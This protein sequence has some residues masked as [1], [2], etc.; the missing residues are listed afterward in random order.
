MH[1][2]FQNVINT[3]AEVKN[4]ISPYIQGL[5]LHDG[6]KN[7]AAMARKMNVSE[8]RLRKQL[9]NSEVKIKSIQSNLKSIANETK[10]IKGLTVFAVDGTSLVKAF[11]EK[12]QNLSIDYDGVIRRPARCLSLMVGALI[13]DGNV[14]PVDCRFW[15]NATKKI[16]VNKSKT[17]KNKKKKKLN[18]NYKTKIMLAIELIHA[19]KDLIKFNYLAMDGA[20]ASEKMIKFIESQ[21]LQYS[22]RIP[23]SRRVI[24]DGNELALRDQPL[25]KLVRNERCKSAKGS[26]KGYTCTFTAHKRKKKSGTWETFFI[27]SNMELSAHGHV[28]AYSRRWPIDKSF[29]SMKQYLGLKDCQMLSGLKQTLHVFNVFLAYSMATIE[30][31]ANAKNSVE[32]IFKIC[33]N[34]KST[35]NHSKNTDS[36]VI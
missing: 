28:I 24:I 1:V 14:I 6:R 21:K 25:L 20:F 19:W 31:I 7:C 2:L 23:R 27:I 5:L 8:K 18:K 15:K 30:K 9:D 22:M 17:K 34:S 3:F 26:Y 36:A 32:E 29:R 11:A 10:F 35:K 13:S 16:G 33:R 4:Q 12:I